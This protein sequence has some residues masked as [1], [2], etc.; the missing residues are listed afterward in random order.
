LHRGQWGKLPDEHFASMR[1]WRAI[2]RE[3]IS[4]L[5]HNAA[6][7]EGQE[8]ELMGRIQKRTRETKEAIE[9][10]AEEARHR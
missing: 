3:R 7:D 10:A 9:K 2:L 6:K 1:C 8:Q 4:K 5:R